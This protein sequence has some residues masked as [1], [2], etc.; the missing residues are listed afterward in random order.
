MNWPVANVNQN[1]TDSRINAQR[2]MSLDKR[3]L[4]P[5][6]LVFDPTVSELRS[7]KSHQIRH[8]S[9]EV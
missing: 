8:G 1:P 3:S 5:R 7:R 6:Q 4:N 9:A 2:R